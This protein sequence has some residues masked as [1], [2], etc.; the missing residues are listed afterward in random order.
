[1]QL[2]ASLKLLPRDSALAFG[3]SRSPRLGCFHLCSCSACLQAG[4]ASLVPESMS[5]VGKED[6]SLEELSLTEVFL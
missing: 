1:M 2:T 3:L 4:P 5:H 6:V